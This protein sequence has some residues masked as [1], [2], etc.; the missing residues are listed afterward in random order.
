[1]LRRI[2]FHADFKSDLDA[3][4]EWLETNKDAHWIE[5]LQR[6]LN[7]ATQLLTR[8]PAVGTIERQDGKIA[9]RRLILRDVPYVIWFVSDLENPRADIWILRLFHARQDRPVAPLPKK[10]RSEKLR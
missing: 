3:Q 6:A 8:F 5:R 2:R 4:L 7:D 10:R 9:L 1:M